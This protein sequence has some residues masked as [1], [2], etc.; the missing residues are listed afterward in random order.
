MESEESNILTDINQ[1]L[2]E[3]KADN[4]MLEVEKALLNDF[5]KVVSIALVD[6]EKLD[7]AAE[8]LPQHNPFNVDLRKMFTEFFS[9]LLGAPGTVDIGLKL[10]PKASPLFQRVWTSALKKVMETIQAELMAAGIRPQN[11]RKSARAVPAEGN[12]KP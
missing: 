11:Q 2:L 6:L 5:A 10:S 3:T 9:N 12:E 8:D 7:K 1:I 4:N